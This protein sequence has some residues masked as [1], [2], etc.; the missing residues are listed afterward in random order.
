MQWLP[1]DGKRL[2]PFLS[3]LVVQRL[4]ERSRI[5][6]APAVE[7]SECRTRRNSRQATGKQ[8]AEQNEFDGNPFH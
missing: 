6:T 7:T 8:G 2:L 1:F 4:N 5:L 3:G